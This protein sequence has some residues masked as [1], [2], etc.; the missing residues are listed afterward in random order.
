VLVRDRGLQALA[1]RR[2]AAEPRHRRV[3]PVRRKID[4][5]DRFLLLT[6]DEDEPLGVQVWLRLAPGLAGRGDI[7]ARLFGGVGRRF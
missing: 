3:Q 6:I 2:S 5:P 7:G 4:P 1:S